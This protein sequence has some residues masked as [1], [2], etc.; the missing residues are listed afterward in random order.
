[1]RTAVGLW[2][3]ASLGVL[4]LVLNAS[5]A[6]W[7]LGLWLATG[8]VGCAILTWDVRRSQRKIAKGWQPP[9]TETD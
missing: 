5:G 3:A 7:W 8:L 9:W 4:G 1:M 2:L 6:L